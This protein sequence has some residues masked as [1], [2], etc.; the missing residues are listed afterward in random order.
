MRPAP[1]LTFG[2]ALVAG[3]AG[4]WYLAGRH[5]QHHKAALFSRNRMQR[6]AALSYLAGQPSVE[7][8]RLLADY[9]AWEPVPALRKGAA[10]VRRRLEREL[11]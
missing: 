5:L 10:R 9:M 8:L 2:A 4:G 7:T 6:M 11:V 1:A 3:F